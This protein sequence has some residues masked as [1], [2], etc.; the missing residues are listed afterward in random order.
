MKRVLL[1]F[2]LL[3][4]VQL[5]NAQFYGDQTFNPTDVGYNSF[6]GP[7]S[8][9][10]AASVIAHA[11]LPNGKI[12][13]GGLITSYNGEG[14]L[15]TSSVDCNLMRINADGS[16]DTTFNYGGIGA[17]ASVRAIAIQPDGKILIGGFFKST[18]T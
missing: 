15:N 14:Y 11:I 10:S 9:S 16:R 13:I 12:L 17:S 18:I 1:V 6:S 5:T 3:I 7:R 2:T 8:G 4:L